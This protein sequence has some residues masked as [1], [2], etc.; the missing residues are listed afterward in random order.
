MIIYHGTTVKRLQGILDNGLRPSNVV[1]KSN[2]SGSMSSFPGYVYL[3]Q[4]SPI[5]YAWKCALKEQDSGIVIFELEIDEAGE[6]EL[7]PDEDSMLKF[8]R[9][10]KKEKRSHD[11]DLR[12][13]ERWKAQGYS[14]AEKALWGALLARY[15]N[16]CS[17]GPLRLRR[18]IILPNDDVCLLSALGDNVYAGVTEESGAEQNR[19]LQ[20]LFSAGLHSALTQ[21]KLLLPCDCCQLILKYEDVQSQCIRS[22]RN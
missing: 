5:Y 11:D 3:T 8:Y 15:G 22:H 17:S 19:I 2:Y 21:S 10:V 13:K 18:Y 7:Y 9:E 4:T 1:G 14:P 20:I 6:F 16:V 12:T